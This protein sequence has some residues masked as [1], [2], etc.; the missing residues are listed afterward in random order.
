MVVYNDQRKD[1]ESETS[2]F[3]PD[4]ASTSDNL[5]NVV[6]EEAN[7]ATDAAK[8]DIHRI[9]GASIENLRLK[10]KEA[11]LTLPGISVL[12]ADTPGEAA[13]A[14]R[15]A[16]PR[17]KQLHEATKTVGSTTPELLRAAGFDVIHAPS[18]A[19]PNRYRIVHTAGV[20]GFADDCLARLSQ[21]FVVT[22]G[23]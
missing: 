3:D 20:R 12:K 5:L 14:M 9:G 1:G 7:S 17:A 22:T 15:A 6:R 13:R 23:H 18:N 10:P 8:F 11:M 4:H 19:F 16:F 2:A 21:V